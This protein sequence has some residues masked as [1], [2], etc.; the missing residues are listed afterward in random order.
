MEKWPE[1]CLWGI[2]LIKHLLSTSFRHALMMIITGGRQIMSGWL[3]A[4]L[5]DFQTKHDL[6]LLSIP[7]WLVTNKNHNK[8][9][10]GFLLSEF[11]ILVH[12]VSLVCFQDFPHC[13]LFRESRPSLLLP[14]PPPPWHSSWSSFL[15]LLPYVVAHRQHSLLHPGDRRLEVVLHPSDSL[16]CHLHLRQPG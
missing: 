10:M 7:N 9:S 8:Q 13:Q 11:S 15:L 14:C 6:W 16:R 1:G 12:T 4:L 2:G 5:Y 3:Q